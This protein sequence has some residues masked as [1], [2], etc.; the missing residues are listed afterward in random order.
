[1]SMPRADRT[2]R[3]T[4]GRLVE[5]VQTAAAPGGIPRFNRKSRRMIRFGARSIVKKA[6]VRLRVPQPKNPL[7]RYLAQRDAE[8]FEWLF[9][10]PEIHAMA[11]GE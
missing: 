4:E 3:V 6:S 10:I 2:Y 7:A 8:A 11:E 9:G 5:P 1:M